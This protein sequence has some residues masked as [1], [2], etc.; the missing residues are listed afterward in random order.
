MVFLYLKFAVQNFLEDREYR[1]LSTKSIEIYKTTLI[2]FQSFCGNN[3]IINAEDITQDVIK[4][5]IVYCKNERGNSPTSCNHKLNN[6]KIWINYLT[7]ELEIFDEKSKPTKKL[8]YQK[9]DVRIEVFTDNQIKQ[10]LAYYRKMKSIEK[11]FYAVRDFTA[12]YTLLGTGIRLGELA[13]LTWDSIDFINFNLTV[14][15]KKRQ[16]SS[17]PLTEK[18]KKELSDYKAYCEQ[19]LNNL[20][21]YIFTNSQGKKLTDNAIKCVFKRLKNVMG[22]QVNAHKFRH[23][24]AHKYIMAGGD[25]FSLQRMLRHNNLNTTQRYVNMWGSALREQNEKYSPLNGDF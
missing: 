8:K 21:E 3:D 16:E 10:M 5:Y 19:Y 25:P 11:G 15:G 6:L 1:N 4:Q 13:N 9:T 23:T 14:Y 17:L 20:P 24:F 18:L 7:E 12:I 22:F 2:E